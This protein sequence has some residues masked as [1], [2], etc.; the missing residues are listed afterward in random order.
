MPGE[1]YSRLRTVGALLQTKLMQMHVGARG[2]TQIMQ[3][4]K[5]LIDNSTQSPENLKAA[6]NEIRMYA[7]QVAQETAPNQPTSAPSP[8]APPPPPVFKEPKPGEV[9]NGKKV[10]RVE[11]VP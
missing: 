8:F 9:R 6:I 11:I 1:D 7:Q 3:H 2:S 5:E 4:F 10:A